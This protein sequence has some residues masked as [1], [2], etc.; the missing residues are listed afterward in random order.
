MKQLIR[1]RCEATHISR[2][3]LPTKMFIKSRVLKSASVRKFP[4]TSAQIKD[5][6]FEGVMQR[7]WILE[8]SLQTLKLHRR[9]CGYS[10]FCCVEDTL[11]KIS[12]AVDFQK[13]NAFVY[14]NSKGDQKQTPPT[15]C[16]VDSS[17]L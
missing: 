7:T 16:V 13:I 6:R 4:L 11:L 10:N 12:S 1:H 15:P 5:W 14:V 17:L 2:N 9:C 3:I 8:L